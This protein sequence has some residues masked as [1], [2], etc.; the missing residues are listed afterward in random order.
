MADAVTG[1]GRLVFIAGEAGVGKSTLL[2][3]FAAHLNHDVRVLK[4]YCD[5]LSTPRALGPL[6]DLD[7]PVLNRLL[8]EETPRELI[9]RQVWGLVE[10]PQSPTVLIV[11]DVHWADEATLD[12]LR[13]L[14]RRMERTRSLAL[15]TYRDEELGALHPLR[16]TIGDLANSECTRRL[17]VPHLSE[18]AVAELAARSG[19]DPNWLYHRTE[20]NP[21]FVTEILKAHGVMPPNVRDVVLANAARLSRSSWSI[22]EA[23]AIHGSP[24]DLHVLDQSVHREPGALEACLDRGILHLEG[25]RVSFRHEL[26]REAIAS[27]IPPSR[28]IALHKAALQHLSTLPISQ[29]NPA[30][31]AYHAEMAGDTAAVLRFSQS[32]AQNAD[33]LGAHLE[34]AEQYERTLRHAAA[35]S[36]LQQATLWESLANACY[37]T[38]QIER[39]EE[40]ALHALE[41]VIGVRN[42]QREGIVR[43]L[44]AK[45]HWAA[46]RFA[47]AELEVEQA[48]MDL[49]S[50]GDEPGFATALGTLA[51]LNVADQRVENAIA[52]GRRTVA[53]AESNGCVETLA[54]AL[55]T[56]GEALLD[57]GELAK[58]RQHIDRGHS[59]A[60]RHGLDHVVAR[61]FICHG[62]GL[63]NAGRP[64]EALEHFQRGMDYCAERDFDLPRMHL[65]AL[66]ARVL[67]TIGAWD[68]SWDR[69]Q[70]VMVAREAA[71]ASRFFAQ[72]VAGLIQAR[73]GHSEFP[74]V[75]DA[76]L[77]LA[78]TSRCASYLNAV[79]AAR[80]EAAYLLGDEARAA[81]EIGTV[82]NQSVSRQDP[83]SASEH[84]YW[85]WKCGAAGRPVAVK[86][87]FLWQIAGNWAE[88][89]AAWDAAAAPYEAARAR[90][91]SDDEDALRM[92]LAEFERLD[93]RPDAARA[94]RRLRRLGVARVPRGP[95]PSTRRHPAGLT[96]REVDVA[97]L[98]ADDLSNQQIAD[99]LFLSPRTVEN[100]VS[101]VLAKLGASTRSDA[102]D[103]ARNL[104]LSPQSK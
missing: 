84:A 38:A 56:L 6:F 49:E 26:A 85:L 76:A 75:L 103:I 29:Q 82:L 71:P 28:A 41:I 21:F 33:H 60:T 69:A 102:A 13:F 57:Q 15:V 31:L 48:A 79:Y 64:H 101:S 52:Y 61:G 89:A 95:R 63:A 92:A 42:R 7:D 96:R 22:L 8:L 25:S 65:T 80:A 50:A 55:M 45:I 67:L 19:L 66:M 83:A 30:R 46:G 4:G 17:V 97:A 51:R 98:L 58:G 87:P 54:D 100:H 34:A 39:A 62:F 93:A 91:E 43:S 73:R 90:A 44:L 10:A 68:E 20:G 59:F 40:A 32:A 70:D 27:A 1:Q 23:A 16:R 88:A 36:P 74:A 11:E 53:V 37:L 35:L 18:A 3:H 2:R 14:G 104:R 86:A 24:C 5:P 72:L 47:D 99:R 12:L 77:D 94:R 9:F 81:I 78:L